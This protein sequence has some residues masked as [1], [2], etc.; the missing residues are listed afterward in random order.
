MR[1]DCPSHMPISRFRSSGMTS[2]LGGLLAWLPAATDDPSRLAS[3]CNRDIEKCTQRQ[4][5]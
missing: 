2:T 4:H 1:M 3:T 5:V